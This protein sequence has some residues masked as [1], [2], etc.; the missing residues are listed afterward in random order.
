MA[1]IRSI[2]PGLFTDEAF[3]SLHPLARLL[4]LGIWTEADDHGVF[5]WKPLQIKMRVMGGDNADAAALM[6]DLAAA[7]TI[8]K[9]EIEGKQYGL[10]RNFCRYQ[11]PKKPA[12]R[13]PFPAEFG[14]YAGLKQESTEPV[15]HLSTTRPEK[16]PQREEEGGKRE[17]IKEKKDIREVARGK[18]S[19]EGPFEE[20][21]RVY[22]KRSGANP[23]KPARKLFERAVKSGTDPAAI[24]AGARNCAVRDSA[25]VGTEFIPQAVKWLRDERWCDY[26]Y[27]AAVEVSSEEAQLR[28]W[29]MFLER[30]QQTGVWGSQ[31]ISPPDTGGCPIPRDMIEKYRPQTG[32]QPHD[33]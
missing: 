7:D 15:P 20:F 30:W 5:E 17:E 1:R 25:K 21:W 11:R 29:T 26:N 14:T 10:I 27:E 4:L 19:L 2:H 28:V 31:R 22:P 9:F 12:Y 33:H 32:G 3:V 18:P 24:I 23:K 13:H 6:N 16:S 8:K